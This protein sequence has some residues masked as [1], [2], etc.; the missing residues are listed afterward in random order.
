MHRKQFKDTKQ[1]VQCITYQA[2]NVIY[3]IVCDLMNTSH[4]MKCI[5]VNAL[6]AMHTLCNELNEMDSMQCIECNMQNTIHSKKNS[7]Q[8]LHKYKSA[9]N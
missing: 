8:I 9:I 2:L 4:I 6:K 3:F 5:E 7:I 1:I